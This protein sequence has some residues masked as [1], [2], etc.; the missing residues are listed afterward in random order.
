M[1]KQ[2]THEGG[3][4]L[5]SARAAVN[6]ASGTLYKHSY[7]SPYPGGGGVCPGSDMEPYERSSKAI[8]PHVLGVRR[9]IDEITARATYIE[10]LL[11]TVWV[12]EYVPERLVKGTMIKGHHEWRELPRDMVI[13]N[14]VLV[15]WVGM[16]GLGR[17][18]NTYPLADANGHVDDDAYIR[19]M[20]RNRAADLHRDANQLGQYLAWLKR[21]DVAWEP[22][23]LRRIEATA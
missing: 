11:S 3:C 23:D 17:H 22:K 21:R 16:D 14:G 18:T 9:S 12:H 10:G 2:S 20:N 19:A 5:C 7:G 15:G 1:V 6:P 8:G 13:V 4:Q